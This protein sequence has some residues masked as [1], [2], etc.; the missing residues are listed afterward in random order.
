MSGLT[1]AATCIY[2]TQRMRQKL[3]VVA[4]GALVDT[5]ASPL[6]SYGDRMR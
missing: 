1:S 5:S 6:N 3:F 4:S 2:G